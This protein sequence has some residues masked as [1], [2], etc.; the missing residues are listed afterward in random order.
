M[1]D[2][3]IVKLVEHYVK[4]YLVACHFKNV[5]DGMEW[6]FARVYGLNMDSEM[7]FFWDEI[8]VILS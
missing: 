1:W 2:K 8:A 7:S 3:H 4:K 6:A 5:D